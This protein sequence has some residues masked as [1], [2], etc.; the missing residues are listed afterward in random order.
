VD[1]LE[2]EH[3]GEDAIRRVC[4]EIHGRGHDV[5]LHIHPHWIDAKPDLCDYDLEQQ[6]Q[7]IARGKELLTRWLG[8]P[9]TAHRAGGY[10]ANADT[11][12]ALKRNGITLDCSQFVGYPRC[13][14]GSMG[15][16]INAVSE[17]EGVTELPVTSFVELQ[18]GQRK[19][20]RLIDV[21]AD[22]AAEIKYVLRQAQ[23]QGLR[24]ATLMLHSFSF[25]GWNKQGTQFWVERD[26]IA[27]FEAVLRFLREQPD[28]KVI[29][30]AEFDRLYRANPSAFLGNDVIPYTGWGLTLWRAC[31]Q[32]N[33]SRKN[34][35]FLALTAAPLVAAVVWGLI[36]YF[37]P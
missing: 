3:F 4:Q 6:T 33:K 20:W 5:Q 30:V 2:A 25:I 22:T 24:V 23:R 10:A 27:K 17:V 18:I 29:T 1:V 8:Q 36:H 12:T 26:D 35:A 14:M 21:D 7:L 11:L 13:R 37:R 16:P 28:M 15:L 34:Q 19:K 31:R 32:F 9:P